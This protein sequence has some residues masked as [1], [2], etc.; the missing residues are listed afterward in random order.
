MGLERAARYAQ[1]WIGMLTGNHPVSVLRTRPLP[2]IDVLAQRIDELRV[3]VTTYGRRVEDVAVVVAGVWPMLDIRRNFDV[4][5]FRDDI[6]RL[7]ELGAEWVVFNVCGDDV[8][9]AEDTLRAFAEA[10]I[11]PGRQS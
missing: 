5:G 8:G 11:P 2:D 6:R 7:E 1:G 9:A 10:V 4:E 3:A